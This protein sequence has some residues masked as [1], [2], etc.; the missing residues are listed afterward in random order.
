MHV[1]TL[2]EFIGPSNRTPFWDDFKGQEIDLK[3]IVFF[4]NNSL[5][6]ALSMY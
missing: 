1:I 4:L 3:L 2:I 6:K 5:N